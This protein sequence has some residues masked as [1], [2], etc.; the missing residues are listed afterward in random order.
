MTLHQLK[1][2]V[3]SCTV[4]LIIRRGRG[5]FQN[6]IPPSFSKGRV[7]AQT[8]LWDKSVPRSPTQVRRIAVTRASSVRVLG[9]QLG[10]VILARASPASWNHFPRNIFIFHTRQQ[11]PISSSL[12]PYRCR[13]WWPT[14]TSARLRLVAFRRLRC[15][16]ECFDNLC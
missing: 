12:S 10:A 13:N 8:N 3:T 14:R 15:R 11:L 7:Q 4:S 16:E 6:I 2:Y 9:V 5:L 1:I